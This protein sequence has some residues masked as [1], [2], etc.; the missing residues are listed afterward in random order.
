M[1]KNAEDNIPL[2]HPDFDM[3]GCIVFSFCLIAVV[4]LLFG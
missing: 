1:G 4:I 2:I 3:D